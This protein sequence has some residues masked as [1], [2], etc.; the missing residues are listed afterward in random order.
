MPKYA[1]HMA[2]LSAQH[3]PNQVTIYTNGSPSLSKEIKQISGSSPGWKTDDRV[4][5]SLEMHPDSN[6]GI[7]IKFED[8]SQATEAFLAHSPFTVPRGPFK[9]QLGIQ[10]GPTGDYAVDGPSNET[11]VKGVFAAGD[12]M[13][14]FKVAT[15][16]I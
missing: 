12:C 8:G 5:K 4:I 1:V 15:N 7:D 6:Y 10:L 9:E 13:T 16:A 11:N 14:M 3:A 2:H